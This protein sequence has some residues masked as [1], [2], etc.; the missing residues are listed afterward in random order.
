MKKS[1]RL[2][3]VTLYLTLVFA[4]LCLAADPLCFVFNTDETGTS[5]KAARCGFTLQ[6]GDS[7]M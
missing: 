2:S 6:H 5:D 3:A 7:M 4:V 1:L